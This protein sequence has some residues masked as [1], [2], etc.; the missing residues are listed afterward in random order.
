MV[1][2]IRKAALPQVHEVPLGLRAVAAAA[3]TIALSEPRPFG[4]PLMFD[5]SLE[6][7][8]PVL[9]FL[10]EHAVQRAHT[11]DT[12]R[13]YSEILYDWFETLEQNHI[14]WRDAAAADLIAYRNR[15]MTQPE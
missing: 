15:M 1:Q 4:F 11:A 7:I 13:T 9:A 2:V 12:V 8:E 5:A 10:H 6:L 14:P 3:H